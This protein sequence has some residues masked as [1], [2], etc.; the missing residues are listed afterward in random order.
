MIDEI[1]QKLVDKQ[2]LE[3]DEPGEADREAMKIIGKKVPNVS[4]YP[5][6]FAWYSL[7]S[8]FKWAWEIL[9]DAPQVEQK[10]RPVDLLKQ[11]SEDK[12]TNVPVSTSKREFLPQ[13]QEQPS[14]KES[15]KSIKRAE[16]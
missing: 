6:T 16:K 15:K 14:K 10:P 2:W 4:I 5:H 3:G 12:L 13:K 8:Q 9:K 7:A 1:E 11:A